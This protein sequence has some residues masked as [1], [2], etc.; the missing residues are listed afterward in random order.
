[1]VSADGGVRWLQARGRCANGVVAGTVQDVSDRKRADAELHGALSLLN[2]TLDAT[3]DGLLVVDLEGRITSF[4][5][6][7]VELW[8]IPSEVLEPRDDDAALEYALRQLANPSFF[9]AKVREL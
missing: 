5:N 9:L 7:F 2:A 6:R 8:R 4:N 3:A 1:V